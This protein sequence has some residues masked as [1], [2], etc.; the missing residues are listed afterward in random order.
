MSRFEV[1][2][3]E[4]EYMCYRVLNDHFAGEKDPEIVAKIRPA[5]EVLGDCVELL[6]IGESCSDDAYSYFT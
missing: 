1:L 6:S 5:L 2:Q 4:T 3:C